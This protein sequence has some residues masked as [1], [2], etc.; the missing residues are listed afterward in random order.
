MMPVVIPLPLTYI[1]RKFSSKNKSI[2]Y[3][4]NLCFRVYSSPCPIEL[5][6]LFIFTS[7]WRSS[8][9]RFSSF[10]RL[11]LLSGRIIFYFRR[12]NP[13]VGNWRFRYLPNFRVYHRDRVNMP[14]Q[15]FVN[16]RCWLTVTPPGWKLRYWNRCTFR[17]FRCKRGSDPLC[18]R[19]SFRRRPFAWILIRRY[20][21][22]LYRL[23]VWLRCS[24]FFFLI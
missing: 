16:F 3:L 18:F 20:R 14:S 17:L 24:A 7:G 8:N 2:K 9:F 21:W 4:V 23:L 1:G 12:N 11:I 13:L 19:L 22:K 6:P 15:R 5:Q 10:R